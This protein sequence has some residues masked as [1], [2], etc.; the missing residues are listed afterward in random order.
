MCKLLRYGYE[1]CKIA[2]GEKIISILHFKLEYLNKLI[3]LKLNK[4]IGN[5][6]EINL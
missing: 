4:Q 3:K 5:Y 6:S 1:K 2:V